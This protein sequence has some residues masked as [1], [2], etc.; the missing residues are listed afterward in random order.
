MNLATVDIE[1]HTLERVHASKRFRNVTERD[2]ILA[3]LRG[4]RPIRHHCSAAPASLRRDCVSRGKILWREHIGP[5]NGLDIV[6]GDHL[7][8]RTR[9]SGRQLLLLKE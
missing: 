7:W 5:G 9:T 4:G 3:C 1:R 8:D 2:H 6:L